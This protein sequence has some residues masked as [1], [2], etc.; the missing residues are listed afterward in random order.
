MFRLSFQIPLES[1]GQRMMEAGMEDFLRQ[2]RDIL[3]N[4]SKWID[5]RRD[6]TDE[7]VTL[8]ADRYIREHC[9]Q[10]IQKFTGEQDIIYIAVSTKLRYR[11]KLKQLIKL[12]SD[13]VSEHFVQRQGN[14]SSAVSTVTIMAQRVNPIL[15]ISESA[16]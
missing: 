5:E 10:R 8:E 9:V 7:D 13:N 2:K 6:Y 14:G 16:K 15:N 1:H 12:T 4:K 3:G 11:V